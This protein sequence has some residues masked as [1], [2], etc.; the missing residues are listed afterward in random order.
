M[1]EDKCNPKDLLKQESIKITKNRLDVLKKM[2]ESGTLLDA[3]SLHKRL[4][5]NSKI[6]LATVYRIL[7]LLRE[8]GILRSIRGENGIELFEMAC[9]HNP[10]HPH[11]YCRKCG[12]TFCLKPLYFDVLK[13]LFP[14][15]E[16]CDVENIA[17]TLSGI[18]PRCKKEKI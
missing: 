7:K 5:A 10:L 8:K 9:Q 11:F 1:E 2:I 12:K 13:T 4:N 15:A 17:I 14:M 3:S 18:C 6:N 16:G